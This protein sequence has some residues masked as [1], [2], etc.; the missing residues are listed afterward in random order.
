[1]IDVG[2]PLAAAN[3]YNRV[4]TAAKKKGRDLILNVAGSLKDT[5]GVSEV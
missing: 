4:K 5:S 2:T 1:M 3:E